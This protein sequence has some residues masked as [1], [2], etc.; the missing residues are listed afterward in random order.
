MLAVLLI[1]LSVSAWDYNNQGSD[2]SGTCSTGEEQ[3]P[4]D[5]NTDNYDVL[6][7]KYRMEIYYYGKTAS[8][9][10][11]NTGNY[12]YMEGDFGYIVV[13]DGDGDERKFLT[14]SVEFHMPSE[15]WFDG[16]ATDME[17]LIFHRI[18][19]SDYTVDFPFRAVVSV[20]IRPGDESYFMNSID[21]YNLPG[22]GQSNVLPDDSNINLLAIVDMDDDYFFY[23]GSLNKPTC[24]EDILW[25][26]FETKQWVSLSQMANFKK[27]WVDSESFSGGK[28]NVREIQ[29][30]NGRTLYYSEGVQLA[31]WIV[32]LSWLV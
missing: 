4:I 22:S 6:G 18:D 7:D 31:A 25:Y 21:V 12:I 20:P 13:I 15:N 32:L 9:T 27:L 8:R 19:D 28:G 1:A 24:D 29:E 5:L 30:K 11:V 3:S 26:I 23:K 14:E 17:M 10:I 16:Y 2:W